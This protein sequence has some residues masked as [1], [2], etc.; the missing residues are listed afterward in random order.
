MSRLPLIDIPDRR[1]FLSILGDIC[2][3]VC[4][5]SRCF[6]VPS[7]MRVAEID[8][9]VRVKGW[10]GGTP[11]H[12]WPLVPGQRLPQ[13]DGQVPDR[14]GLGVDLRVNFLVRY[15]HAHFS[16][17][18]PV[19]QP[20]RISSPVTSFSSGRRSPAARSR[21]SSGPNENSMSR[22]FR[23]L[24]RIRKCLPCLHGGDSRLGS[25]A[26][27]SQTWWCASIDQYLR[28]RRPSRS[29]GRQRRGDGPRRV[30]SGGGLRGGLAVY[31]HR[32]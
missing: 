26:D 8:G 6:R 32:P 24:A 12:P 28:T 19:A 22:L 21:S 10:G 18:V 17:V 3:S 15:R 20:A 13:R 5:L 25:E 9:K 11:G 29:R 1:E 14:F 2:G 23:P 16:L 30:R 4:R 27:P 7:G 31:G